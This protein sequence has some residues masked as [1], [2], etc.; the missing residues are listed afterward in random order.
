MKNYFLKTFGRNARDITCECERSNQP[1]LV[2]V[3]HLS[4]G[5]TLNDKLAAKEGRVTQILATDPAPG[6]TRGR[7]LAPRPLAEAHRRRAEAARGDAREGAARGEAADRRR[8]VLVA[9]HEPRVP[10]QALRRRSRHD[11]RSR[12]ARTASRLRLGV[13]SSPIPRL[14]PG[15]SCVRAWAAP[16]SRP[17]LNATSRRSCAPTAPAATTT[18]RRSRASPWSGSRRSAQGGDGAGDPDRAWRCRGLGPHPAD[19]EPGRRPH[20]AAPTSRRFRPPTSPR[21]R[22][23][24]RRSSRAGARRLDSRNARGAGACRRSP[25]RSPSPPPPSRPTARGWPWPAAARSRSWP[26]R[27]AARPASRSSRSPTCP[28]KVA[29]VHFTRDGT[30]LVIAGGD[31]RASA[32]WPRSATRRRARSCSRSPATATCSTTPNS[33]PTRTTLATAG[34]DRSIKLWNAADGT[35]VRSIDVHNGAV[36]DLAWHP[37]GKVLGSA[38]ADETIKLWRASDGVRL[39]TL[40]Q[41][42][43]EM[44]GVAFTPDGGHVIGVGRDKR[45]HLWKLV[46]ARRAGDQSGRALAIRPRDADRGASRSRPTAGRLMTTAEDRSLKSWSLPDLVLEHDLPRQPDLVA[47]VVPEAGG[48]FI[49]GRMDGSLDVWASKPP[50]RSLRPVAA[51]Q[52]T[53]AGACRFASPAAETPPRRSPRR[54]PTTRPR[55]RSRSPC[56]RRSPARSRPPATPT[57][58]GSRPRRACR[59][60]LRGDR[61]VGQA[62]IEARFAARDPR[63]PGTAGRAGGAAGRARFVVHVSRQELDADRRLPPAELG[64]DGTRRISL[65]GGRGGEALALPARPRLGLRGLSGLGQPPH[66]LPHHGDRARPRRAG[67]DR[68]AAAAGRD[69]RAQRPA[70]VPLSLRKRR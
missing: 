62:E 26:S 43:G 19:Q 28:G 13:I 10:L 63:C 14:P 48:R 31:R 38:S 42:Q 9:A 6:E 32:A 30:R 3:L 37:S 56:P 64:R 50:G 20:A 33:R 1:S 16:C 24:S 61:R 17:R 70:R 4:N 59:S 34:Y 5:S 65:R 18:A 2:Q 7:G 58:S 40:S 54:S 55:R 45:I 15:A 51:S 57:A 46:V 47:A 25:A 23:G 41:P 67:L 60:S 21:S 39:D 35:L 22:P 49:V 12:S 44:A 53:A 66:V 29:A 36:Y 8:H 52:A 68:G 11:V 69:A 27:T